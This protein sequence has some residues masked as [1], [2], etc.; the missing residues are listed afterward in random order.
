MHPGG[1]SQG[2]L[3]R[4][5]FLRQEGWNMPRKENR[6]RIYT[7]Q[8]EAC[9]NC[10]CHSCTKQE[11]CR[12]HHPILPGMGR[13]TLPYPCQSCGQDGAYRPF[14]PRTAVAICQMYITPSAHK[15]NKWDS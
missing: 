12:L 4:T 3:Y 2:K 11:T 7:S 1:R 10:Q 5:T 15:Y 14:V 9:E 6:D 13:D 8:K